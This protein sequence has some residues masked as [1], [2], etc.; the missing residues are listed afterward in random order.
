MPMIRPREGPLH[1]RHIVPVSRFSVDSDRSSF[2]DASTFS[3]RGTPV[4]GLGLR[5]APQRRAT[6]TFRTSMA[7]IP[8]SPTDE[9]DNGDSLS[10]IMSGAPPPRFP[11]RVVVPSSPAD[12]T[13]P[14]EH[15]RV[16]GLI[17]RSPLSPV[18]AS[19]ASMA[20]RAVR[21]PVPPPIVVHPLPKSKFNKEFS[22]EYES[23]E[24]ATV[25][26]GIESLPVPEEKPKPKRKT[27]LGFNVEGW[28]ELGLL[29]RMNTVRRK[30]TTK[31]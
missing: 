18:A 15:K 19:L 1:N 25:V 4:I 16:P 6:A 24:S 28:W 12:D 27:I 23:P 7:P 26:I 8:G 14:D 22:K 11:P 13:I 31:A 20:R 5:P 21:R 29:E 3:Q 17:P 30:N 2:S 9:T 10:P